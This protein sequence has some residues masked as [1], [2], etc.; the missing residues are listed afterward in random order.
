VAVAVALFK[1]ET[2]I[3]EP[4]RQEVLGGLVL[5]VLAV[6]VQQQQPQRWLDLEVMVVA[7]GQEPLR[8]SLEPL[9]VCHL[10]QV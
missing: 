10:T 5:E 8:T 7:A 4:P 1:V 9:E 6:L 2:A 3:L